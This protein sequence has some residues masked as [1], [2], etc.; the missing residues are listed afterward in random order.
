M[1]TILTIETSAAV[2]SAALGFDGEL[3][4]QYSEEEPM[5]HA[6]VL[7][8]FIERLLS[9]ARRRERPID[10]V[11]VSLGPG[12]YTGLRIGL[13]QAK[14]L[15]FALDVPLIGIPTLE[16]MA[17]KAMFMPKVW[18][19]NEILMSM[20]DARRMEVYT[21]A[22]DFALNELITPGAMI[23][24]AH[25]LDFL[26][27]DREIFLFGSG[28]GKCR[29]VLADSPRSDSIHYIDVPPLLASDIIPLAERAVRK[30]EY[31]DLAYS[32]PLYLKEA[33]TTMP[34]SALNKLPPLSH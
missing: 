25:S 2:C 11:A 6:E 14:G 16:A 13:S 31:L 29:E 10:A 1:S 8:P 23:V 15:C 21:C 28:A 22:Y 32:T 3:F 12:S 9:D 5:K 19:G 33:H 17:V 20:V 34:K 18:E 30:G 7:S 24:D 26:P 27:D 4:S